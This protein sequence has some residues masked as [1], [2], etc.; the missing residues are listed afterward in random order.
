MFKFE[1]PASQLKAANESLHFLNYLAFKRLE[2]AAKNEGNAEVA[3][4]AKEHADMSLQASGRCK[5]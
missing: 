3:H 5:T 4:F 1:T 2:I